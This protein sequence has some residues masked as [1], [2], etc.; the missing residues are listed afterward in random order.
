MRVKTEFQ[1]TNAECRMENRTRSVFVIRHSSFVIRRAFSLVELMVAMA[2]LSLIV[3]AL[4]AVFSSTQTAFRAASTQSDV[5]EAGRNAMDLIAEDLRQAAL[6]GGGAFT[7]TPG[8]PVNFFV[9][10][11]LNTYQPLVQPLP[12]S[13]AQRT[14][15]LQ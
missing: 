14:N 11:N 7:N 1:M 9:Y 6:S 4:M 3:I 5:L 10:D 15:L 2:L 8:G 12:G 13:T